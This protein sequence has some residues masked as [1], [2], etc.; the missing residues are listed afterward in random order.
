MNADGLKAFFC[1]NI[2]F[3]ATYAAPAWFML[4]LDEKVQRTATHN[5]L[6]DMEYE[7]RLK[8]IDIPCF[9]MNLCQIVADS[10]HPLFS[11]V[12]FNENRKSSRDY[13]IFDPKCNL[14]QK[15]AHSLFPLFM[16]RIN[17]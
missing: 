7:E 13:T 16:S 10:S 14:T 17:S 8:L 15:C 9:K 4:L 2:R 11:C 6:P 12:V 3:I 5:I 1:S